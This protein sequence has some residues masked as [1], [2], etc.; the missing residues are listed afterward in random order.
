M[1]GNLNSDFCEEEEETSVHI[2]LNKVHQRLPLLLLCGLITTEIQFLYKHGILC[3]KGD[4]TW[5]ILARREIQ[6]QTF[7]VRSRQ[8]CI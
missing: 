7:V 8:V 1:K 4:Q 2:H 3:H 6:V 5:S